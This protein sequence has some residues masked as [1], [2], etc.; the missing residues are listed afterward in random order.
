MGPGR[1]Y[2]DGGALISDFLAE[3]L[4]DDLALTK[5]SLLLGGGRSTPVSPHPGEYT[6]ASAGCQELAQ[7][8]REAQLLQI[9]TRWIMSDLQCPATLIIAAHGE[10]KNAPGGV[11]SWDAGLTVKGREQVRHLVRQIAQRRIAGVYSSPMGSAIESAELAASELG[12]R[13]VVVEGLQELSA[14]DLAGDSSHDEQRFTE[15]IQEIAD[16]HRGETVL[17]FSH[18][19]AMTLAI[20]KL[21]VNARGGLAGQRFLPN[22]AA[23]EVEVD[24]DGWR[25]VSWPERS[26]EP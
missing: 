8:V 24:A 25:L 2:I 26:E 22:C 9:P 11:Q 4:I 3:G 6:L 1:V 21:S 14:V 5:A 18:A 13:S 15:A 16:V 19:G 17:V 23:A 10:A 12:L 20:P 7:R